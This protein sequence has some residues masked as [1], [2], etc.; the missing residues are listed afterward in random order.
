MHSNRALVELGAEAEHVGKA[1]EH[2]KGAEH[3]GK[4]A[5]DGKAAEHGKGAE[6]VGKAAEYMGK[7]R[8]SCCSSVLK[9]TTMGRFLFQYF[10]SF[11]FLSRDECVLSRESLDVAKGFP[12]SSKDR[13]RTAERV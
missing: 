11:F 4:A 12:T 7:R 6:Y 5:E 3:V 1:A 9:Y 13:W 10:F 8:S 2:G